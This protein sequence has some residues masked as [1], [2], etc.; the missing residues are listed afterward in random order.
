MDSNWREVPIASLCHDIFDGPHATPKKTESGPVFLGISSLK[1]G[2]IDLAE[3]AHLSEQDFARWTKRVTPRPGDVV[4]SYETRLGEAAQIPDGLRCCLGRRMG[5]LRPDTSKVDARFLLYAYLAPGFQ[6]TI[7]E[8]TVR[9]STVDRIL[10]TEFGRFPILVPPLDEQ[11]PI[12]D[13]LGALDDKIELNRE[14]TRTIEATVR[15]LFQSWFIDFDP[16]VAKSA[17]RPPLGTTAEVA[18][19]FPD[20][21]VD[22]EIGP[23]PNGWQLAVLGDIARNVRAG[24]KAG[25]LGTYPAYIALE[26]MPRR[27]IT[28]GEWDGTD[29]LLSGKFQF[30]QGDFLFGKLRPYFHKVG[31][32]PLDG[33]CSTDILVIQPKDPHW[34]GL[35]LGH[36]SSDEFVDYT[37][38]GSIGTK[39]P[40]TDWPYMSRYA[41]ALPPSALGAAF[42]EVI[43]PMLEKMRGMIFE[44]RTLGELRDALIP[45]LLTG[46]V[47]IS[48]AE[49]LVEMAI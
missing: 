33:V 43:A 46:D 42:N 32:A 36:L 35:L 38:T 14:M 24:V 6:E 7:R 41:L 10:L 48:P 13:L 4:F 30:H 27:S 39:M 21:F 29:G 16:V 37:D 28:L 11:K 25:Q 40:R 47:R 26:H 23:I 17:G 49:R 5:L 34:S 19:L 9:G 22:S 31:V 44:S 8:R 2:R 1:H 45:R 12:A 3:S 15:A 18:A 20:Q